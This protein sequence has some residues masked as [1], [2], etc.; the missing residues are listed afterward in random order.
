MLHKQMR[1][2]CIFIMTAGLS[3]SLSVTKLLLFMLLHERQA[4][5]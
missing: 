3:C 1:S 2:Y 5:V 4:G